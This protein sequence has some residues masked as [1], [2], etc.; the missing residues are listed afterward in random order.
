MKS[1]VTRRAHLKFTAT[2]T[3]IITTPYRQKTFDLS[4]IFGPLISYIDLLNFTIVS[5]AKG[6]R[7][8]A[9]M[10][11]KNGLYS[12][13]I[14]ALPDAN[15]GNWQRV[16]IARPGHFEYWMKGGNS[17]VDPLVEKTFEGVFSVKLVD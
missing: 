8:L 11:N 2:D 6:A 12:L 9:S 7:F 16:G 15:S 5:K 1:L 13:D 17:A 14:M 10:T 4:K 3:V